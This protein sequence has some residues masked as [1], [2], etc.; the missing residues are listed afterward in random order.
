MSMN[1]KPVNSLG[2][3]MLTDFSKALD[4]IEAEKAKG[5]ILT[6]VSSCLVLVLEFIFSDRKK[7]VNKVTCPDIML[8][9]HLA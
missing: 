6:S 2:L 3:G 5:V 9:A 4:Q 7:F 8:P 1:R